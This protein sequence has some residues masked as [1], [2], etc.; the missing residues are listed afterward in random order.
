MWRFLVL[1]PT[2]QFLPQERRGL[3]VVGAATQAAHPAPQVP[4][5]CPQA[6]ARQV[7]KEPASNVVCADNVERSLAASQH[8]QERLLESSEVDDGGRRLWCKPRGIVSKFAPD[9][10]GTVPHHRLG[11]TRD[12]RHRWWN[13]LV[14]RKRDEVRACVDDCRTR[15]GPCDFKE[16]SAR[17]G[18]R[19]LTVNHQHLELRERQGGRIAAHHSEGST[20]LRRDTVARRHR[21]NS[22]AKLR[23]FCFVRVEGEQRIVCVFVRLLMILITDLKLRRTTEKG[24]HR[25]IIVLDDPPPLRGCSKRPRQP[26]LA[27]TGRGWRPD[28]A[29]PRSS[30]FANRTGSR[31]SDAVV[32]IA[33]ALDRRQE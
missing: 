12:A 10:G 8:P 21:A 16:M 13:C 15:S 23:F 30:L 18:A 6:A 29:T 27:R 28:P 19:G 26:R 3:H 9:F 11:E 22:C 4:N 33:L 25:T 32:S 24:G 2:H 1:E 17:S 7:G 20:G 14:P 5:Q 31:R